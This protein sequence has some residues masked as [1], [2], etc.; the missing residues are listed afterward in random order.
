MKECWSEG[1]LRA[2]VDGELPAEDAER[3]A[4][5]LRVCGA[6]AARLRET[7]DRARRIGACLAELGEVPAVLPAAQARK[8]VWKWAL[9]A[10]AL[11]AAFA[12]ALILRPVHH[13]VAVTVPPALPAAELPVETARTVP[14]VPAAPIVP[15]TVA[16][17]RP[18]RHKAA[19]R[20]TVNYFV[21]LDDEPIDTGV[22]MRMAL[23]DGMQADVI[24]DS[25]GR[26]RAIRP[27]SYVAGK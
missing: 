13:P 1:D 18:V 21:A 26:A 24:V 20:P 25:T 16:A 19:P 9:A 5:H 7:E 27:V 4:A 17:K 2:C 12:V 14:A 6:C 10:A 11:A 3:L 15:Q 22:V 23:E 8:P